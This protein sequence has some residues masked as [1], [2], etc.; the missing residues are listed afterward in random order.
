[1]LHM[2]ACAARH[3]SCGADADEPASPLLMPNVAA[4]EDPGGAVW[5][6][7]GSEDTGWVRLNATS[8]DG[9]QPASADWNLTFR[10]WSYA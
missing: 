1:M 8:A 3:R 5:P 10:T 4:H 2:A 9:I 6:M 7:S